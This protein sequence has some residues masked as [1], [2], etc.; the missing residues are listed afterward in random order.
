MF[1]GLHCNF[2]KTLLVPVGKNPGA[3]EVGKFKV[4]T[5]FTLLGMKID[6]KLSCLH[7]NLILQQIR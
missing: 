7:A 5:Q 6:S 3:F 1:S 4:A 2:D